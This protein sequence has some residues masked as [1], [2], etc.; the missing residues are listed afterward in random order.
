M[1]T[2]S[3]DV[4]YRDPKPAYFLRLE[5]FPVLRQSHSLAALFSVQTANPL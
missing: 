2:H 4:V 5:P 3:R 1:L